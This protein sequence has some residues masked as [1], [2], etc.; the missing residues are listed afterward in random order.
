MIPKKFIIENKL[1]FN[2]NGKV[3]KLFT[4]NIKLNTKL[5]FYL[6]FLKVVFLIILKNFLIHKKYYF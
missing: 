5:F 3:D 1:K 6:K 2:K 4:K